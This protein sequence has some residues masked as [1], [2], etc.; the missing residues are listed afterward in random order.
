[1]K[2]LLLLLAAFTATATVASA[3]L[4][5]GV[6]GGLNIS[7]ISHSKN[8][9]SFDKKMTTGIFVG[10]YVEYQFNDFLAIQP[11]LL[12]SRQGVSSKDK[13]TEDI[14]RKAGIRLNY[15]NLPILVKFYPIERLSIDVGP[16][17]GYALSAKSIGRVVNTTDGRSV[18][19]TKDRIDKKDYNHFDFGVAMGASYKLMNNFSVFARYYLGV[20]KINK[21]D[22]GFIIS[23]KNLSNRVIQIGIGCGF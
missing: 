14:T 4:S 1:M 18:T 11:E 21:K 16:Q 10:A 13:S 19:R 22:N 8:F 17:I 15:L 5:Y 23:D 12:Y 20:T 2:K 9:T 6:K 3:Q 7:D